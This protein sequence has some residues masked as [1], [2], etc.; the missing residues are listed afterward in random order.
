MAP[1]NKTKAH[2][3]LAEKLKRKLFGMKKRVA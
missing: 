2:E 1:E 3:G